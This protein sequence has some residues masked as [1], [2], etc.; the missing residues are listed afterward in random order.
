MTLEYP[1]IKQSITDNDDMSLTHF[2]THVGLTH[3]HPNKIYMGNT[4]VQEMCC[5]GNR[6]YCKPECKELDGQIYVHVVTLW[7]VY[8]LVERHS[9]SMWIFFCGQTSEK[10]MLTREQG[11]MA[12]KDASD[13]VI[14][15][16]EVPA[17]R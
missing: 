11:E 7:H 17:N 15:K 5:Q 13:T 4:T 10:Q 8:A 1:I 6:L 12:A 9:S 14:Y 16:I 3:T 2:N